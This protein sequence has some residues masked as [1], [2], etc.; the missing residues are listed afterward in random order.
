MKQRSLKFKLIVGGIMV[1]IIPLMV[2]GFF[3]INKASTAIVLLAEGR[4]EIVAKNL[5]TMTDMTMKEEIKFANGLAIDPIV[6]NAVIKV[7]EIGVDNS[8][9]EL[10]ILDTFL[11]NIVKEVG[12]D[13]D[14]L[15]I[16]DSKGFV[17]SDSNDNGVNREKKTSVSEREYFTYVKENGKIIVGSP[18]LSK[19]T[20][21][22]ITVVAIPLKT[23]SGEF[24]G[25]FGLSIK[26]AS[27]SNKITEVKIGNTGYPF[28]V[29]K[30]GIVIAHPN[31]D[32]ILKLDFTTLNGMESIS[33]KMLSQKSGVDTYNF[34]GINKIAGF[35]PVVSTGWS[36]C[37]TQE[38]SEFLSPVIEIRNMILMVGGIFLILTLLCVIWFVK[39]I[40]ILLGQ[41]PSELAKVADSIANGDLTVNFIQTDGKLTGV[42]ANMKEMTDKLKIMFADI[43]GG[44][45]TLTLS[46]TELSTISERMA[47]GADETSQQSNNV[48]VAAE[49]MSTNMNS[50]AASTEQTSANIQMIVAAAEEMSATINEIAQN[51]AKGG[52]TT[53]AAVKKAETVSKKVDQLGKAA[54]EIS[55]VT[56]TI[57]DISEQTNLLALNATIEA[58]RAGVAGKGFAVVAAEIKVLAQQTAQATKEI[59]S[60]INDV[61]STT[62]ESV[63]AIQSIVDIIN[64]I[65]TVVI[66]VA[67]AIEEQSATTQ[68]I[69][70]NVTQAATGVHEVNENVNK[71]SIVAK[72]I[73]ENITQVSKASAEMKSGSLH[74]NSSAL[75]LSKLAK[76]LN[77][78]IS[79]FKL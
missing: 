14:V 48:S 13:Y 47:L 32:H 38:D 19:T 42:Y 73:T 34:K 21:E 1:A 53:A 35:A 50:V 77:E 72:E 76:T 2:V 10:K 62:D 7:S 4:A 25:M 52:E 49:E 68:E 20:G 63:I 57:S 65:N 31:Q 40:M 66:S 51:T 58:A 45:Q 78:M 59:G 30:K 71:T 79:R 28:M 75:D 6:K 18:V 69:V 39:G 11:S 43:L 16:T 37:V 60:K 29:D 67:S 41:D 54:S 26:L 56:E 23:F 74:V 64:E 5:A 9:S 8:I 15:F 36:I 22:P 44:V 33:G 17:I 12:I 27:L 55:K 61:Q 70:N 3:S 24:V 46:S